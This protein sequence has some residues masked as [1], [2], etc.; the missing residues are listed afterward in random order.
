MKA[1]TRRLADTFLDLH[2]LCLNQLVSMGC[3]AE[4]GE[5][6]PAEEVSSALMNPVAVDE[7]EDEVVR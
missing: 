2:Q 5:A 4:K 3:T 6:V 7:A 1:I